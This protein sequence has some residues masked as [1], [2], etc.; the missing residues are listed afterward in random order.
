[1]RFG[2][3]ISDAELLG[4]ARKDA[5]VLVAADAGLAKPEHTGLRA[6]VECRYGAT[7]EL[8]EVG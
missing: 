6:A 8:S 5:F 3:L 7:L 4:I 1:L 2:S